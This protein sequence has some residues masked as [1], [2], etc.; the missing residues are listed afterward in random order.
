M[1][2]RQPK[3]ELLTLNPKLVS[4]YCSLLTAHCTAY[5]LLLSE[6]HCIYAFSARYEGATLPVPSVTALEQPYPAFNCGGIPLVVVLIE[7][8]IRG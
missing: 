5:C 8:I 6:G 7:E 1:S 4:D 2:R 3:E